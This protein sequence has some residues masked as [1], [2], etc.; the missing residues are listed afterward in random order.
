MAPRD[1]DVLVLLGETRG[2]L[3]QS[4]LL[5]ELF[6]REEGDAPPVD[7][8]AERAA[9]EFVRA[10]KAAGLVARG[11]RPLA[12]AGWRWRRRRWRWPAAIGVEIVADDV[13]DAAGVVLRRGPGAL[14]AR[15]PRRR[16]S[17]GCW[18]GRVEARVPLRDVGRRSA[19][20]TMRLGARGG[21]GS[22]RCAAAHE[23]G[24]ARLL[25]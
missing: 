22:T 9:G 11:A 3:G 13:L 10:A 1:G 6:G 16:T 7:L 15:L 12:T 20:T 23:R 17:G 8:A 21:R 18:R 25:D 24:L 5:A 4:A 14:P 19:A 2:H